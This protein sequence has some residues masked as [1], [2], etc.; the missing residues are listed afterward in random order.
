MQTRVKNLPIRYRQAEPKD[1]SRIAQIFNENIAL[2]GK[3]LWKKT[4]ST[5]E[6]AEMASKCDDREKIYVLTK[7][8]HIIGWGMIKKYLLKA[9]YDRTCE[10]SVFLT[11]KETGKG[12]GTPFK[13]YI[14][15][16]CKILGYHHVVAKIISTNSR[17]IHYNQKLGYEIVG[18]QKE[19]GFENGKYV[20]VVIM[21]YLIG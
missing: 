8:D 16:N 1:H 21:Q 5:S 9:G 15:D 14:L 13:K 19:I 11:A 6:I 10:T 7:G 18:T 2:G 4:F 20:D 12:Y 17:S 3:T